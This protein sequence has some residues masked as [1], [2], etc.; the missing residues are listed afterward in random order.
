MLIPVPSLTIHALLFLGSTTTVVTAE[1]SSLLSQ[2][3]LT[4]IGADN[5]GPQAMDKLGNGQFTLTISTKGKPDFVEVTSSL[6]GNP[7]TEAV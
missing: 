2:L 3:F 1:S 4:I 7:I 5:V 6:N